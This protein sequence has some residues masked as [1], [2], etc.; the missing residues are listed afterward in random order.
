ML[1]LI[2]NII[3]YYLYTNSKCSG[4]RF[5]KR[6]LDMT[7]LYLS[8]TTKLRVVNYEKVSSIIDDTHYDI[9]HSIQ[10]IPKELKLIITDIIGVGSSH[11][12]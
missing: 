7:N 8:S 2:C 6:V 1:R 10:K 11:P 5:K 4:I 9:I 3:L 12:N